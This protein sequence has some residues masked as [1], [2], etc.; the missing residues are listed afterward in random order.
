MPNLR[1][2]CE[3]LPN[4]L[5]CPSEGGH[6]EA[7][8]ARGGGARHPVHAGLLHPRGDRRAGRESRAAGWKSRG[9]FP[10]PP[11]RGRVLLRPQKPQRHVG[12]GQPGGA[13]FL[14]GF[15]SGFCPAPPKIHRNL[16]IQWIS[17]KFEISR[18]SGKIL[19]DFVNKI[20]AKFRRNL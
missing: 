13:G 20:L 3:L 10:S 5:I 2:C 15:G 14:A 4:L 17:V 6:D 19:S 1:R 16:Q 12:G 9:F 8:P 7:T 11:L 18:N